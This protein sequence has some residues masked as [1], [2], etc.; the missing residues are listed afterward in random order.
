MIQTDP[1]LKLPFPDHEPEFLAK[2]TPHPKD[3]S[4]QFEEESHVYRC[5]FEDGEKF[6]ENYIL[7]TSGV[8]HA[9]FPHFDADNVIQKMMKSRNW[10]K[11]KYHGMLKEDIKSM[12]T[13]NGRIASTRGTLL[14]FLLECHNNGFDLEHSIYADLPDI[15]AYFKWRKI[16]FESEKLVPF[17]T[18]MRMR[19]G[20]DLRITGTADLLAIKDDHRLPSET[21]G[22][23]TL[24]M[25][26]WKFSKGIQKENKYE[27]GH[28]PCVTLPNCNYSH[29]LLQ[30]NLYKWLLETYYK[31]WTWRGHKYTR[32]HVVSKHLAIFHQNHGKDGYMYMDLPDCHDVIL[33]MIDDRKCQVSRLLKS[34]RQYTKDT[35][36]INN[37]AKK[38]KI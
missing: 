15:K 30:Q 24:H 1:V 6:E 7:S 19:T 29:Y 22:V 34:K 11:S 37:S 3:A 28:G 33:G 38:P 20:R 9:Y 35:I 5:Q 31:N 18:E 12:W 21:N 27:N 25:I 10:S 17:R 8:V 14:H 16:H 13:E 4:I 36:I 26:D 23:L 32:L 2:E